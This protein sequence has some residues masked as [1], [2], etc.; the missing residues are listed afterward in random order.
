MTGFTMVGAIFGIVAFVL[1]LR[2][3]LVIGYLQKKVEA[4]EEEIKKAKG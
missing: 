2:A 3:I 1:A 4:L